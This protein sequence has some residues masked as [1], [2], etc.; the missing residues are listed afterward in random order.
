MKILFLI[1][2]LRKGGAERVVLNQADGLAQK[3]HNVHI[4]SW[5][6]NINRSKF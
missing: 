3:G 2:S 4:I 1:H 6:D 5:L